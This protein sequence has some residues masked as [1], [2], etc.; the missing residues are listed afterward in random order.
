MY[1]ASHV[2]WK[3]S[4]HQSVRVDDHRNLQQHVFLAWPAT[5]V[6]CCHPTV[7]LASQQASRTAE[8]SSLCSIVPNAL[9]GKGNRHTEVVRL[10]ALRTGLLY[11]HE[12]FL[13][14]ISVRGW[15]NPMA[16]VRPKALC[17][18]K[19]PMTP[20]GIEPATIRLVAQCLNHLCHCVFRNSAKFIAD[21]TASYSRRL[22]YS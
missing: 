6:P 13:V 11:P 20:S 21:Y 15:V 16:I 10:S 14:L 12:I 4:N 5:T 18:W 2:T 7:F 17:Q 22:Q 8:V 3:S 9:K 19:I 1:P